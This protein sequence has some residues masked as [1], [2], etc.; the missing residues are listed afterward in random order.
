MNFEKSQQNLDKADFVMF[1]VDILIL[2]ALIKQT[3]EY[4]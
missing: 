4:F 1:R 2:F 3:M